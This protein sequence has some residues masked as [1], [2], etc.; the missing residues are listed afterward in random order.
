MEAVR[1]FLLV[2]KCYNKFD[3]LKRTVTSESDLHTR[4]HVW[5]GGLARFNSF[6]K[7]SLGSVCPLTALQHRQFYPSKALCK[8]A[9]DDLVASKAMVSSSRPPLRSPSGRFARKTSPEQLVDRVTTSSTTHTRSN[10]IPL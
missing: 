7:G 9:K 5:A 3:T 1:H 6:S 10:R 4:I 2:R 8:R